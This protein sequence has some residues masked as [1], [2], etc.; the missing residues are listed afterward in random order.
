M[1]TRDFS[2]G[3]DSRCVRLTTYQP[4][5]A[6]RQEKSG[7]LSYLEPLGPVKACCERPL[8]LP[9]IQP[10]DGRYSGR[11]MLL[12]LAIQKHLLSIQILIV[13]FDCIVSILVITGGCWWWY[14]S[15]HP[16]LCLQQNSPVPSGLLIR[17]N[18]WLQVKFIMWTAL[19]IFVWTECADDCILGSNLEGKRVWGNFDPFYWTLLCQLPGDCSGVTGS[20]EEAKSKTRGEIWWHMEAWDLLLWPQYSNFLIEITV[21]E[22]TNLVICLD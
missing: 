19:Q 12:R 17:L 4:R 6:K 20:T 11:N 3:K 10:D 13:L 18:I 2:W 1:S 21:L 7:A 9:F 22:V 15:M 5:S 16:L 8:P 14:L